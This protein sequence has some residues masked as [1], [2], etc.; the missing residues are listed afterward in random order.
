MELEVIVKFFLKFCRKYNFF[1]TAR[2]DAIFNPFWNLGEEKTT[3]EAAR[4][5]EANRH[6]ILK[7]LL[8]LGAFSEHKAGS[9]SLKSCSFT[10]ENERLEQGICTRQEQ[11]NGESGHFFSSIP[12][13]T[14]HVG[15][16]APITCTKEAV[17][18]LFFGDN[19]I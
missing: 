8:A 11:Y 14:V 19:L 2:P 1:D 6:Q 10:Y 9:S 16:W 12:L 5:K 13:V 15:T 17:V 3:T 7:S 4:L 18:N